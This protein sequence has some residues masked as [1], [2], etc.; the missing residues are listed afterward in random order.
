ML[1]AAVL[2][3]IMQDG[4]SG[5][6]P[7]QAGFDY[8]PGVQVR[9]HP[10]FGEFLFHG[11]FMGGYIAKVEYIPSRDIT[12]ALMMNSTDLRYEMYHAMLRGA[13]LAELSSEETPE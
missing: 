9:Q 5:Q 2:A 11:G 10:E 4:L 7:P 6:V 1:T 8:G 13:V 3:G 12:I